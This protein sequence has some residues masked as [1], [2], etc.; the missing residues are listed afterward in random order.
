MWN[1]K[2]HVIFLRIFLLKSCLLMIFAHRTLL[3]SSFLKKQKC[4]LKNKS[5]KVHSL[6]TFR[7]SLT[8]LSEKK[9]KNS[10]KKTFKACLSMLTQV[11]VKKRTRILSNSSSNYS[12]STIRIKNSS[13]KKIRNTSII[14]KKLSQ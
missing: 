1:K 2:K 8:K 3:K 6:K 7:R 12:L 10:L 5:M 11:K 4:T 13:R 9:R 14:W